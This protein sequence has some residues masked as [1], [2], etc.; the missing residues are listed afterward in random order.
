MVDGT[1]EPLQVI[2]AGSEPEK[3]I[4]LP[5][6]VSSCEAPHSP[7]GVDA[8]HEPLAGQSMWMARGCR[9]Q[10]L[11]LHTVARRAKV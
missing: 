10:E 1:G 4:V 3:Y 7:A 9:L 8:T 2:A 5:L 6:K 11:K